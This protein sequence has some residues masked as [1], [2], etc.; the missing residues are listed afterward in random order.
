MKNHIIKL[1]LLLVFSNPAFA[2][3]GVGDV[4]FDPSTEYQTDITAVQNI[5]QT[6]KQVEQYQTQLQQYQNQIQNT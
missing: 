2:I 1:S 6:A 3:F 4:V 5:A